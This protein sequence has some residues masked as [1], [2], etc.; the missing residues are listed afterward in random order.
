MK[1][2]SAF[3]VGFQ[4]TKAQCSPL[5]SLARFTSMIPNSIDRTMLP[6]LHQHSWENWAYFSFYMQQRFMMAGYTLFTEHN[7]FMEL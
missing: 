2:L 5:L 6:A 1:S 7:V 4:Q 3:S